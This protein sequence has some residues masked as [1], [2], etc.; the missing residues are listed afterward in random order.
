MNTV[1]IYAVALNVSEGIIQIDKDKGVSGARNIVHIIK[2]ISDSIDID[3][4]NK[5]II[6]LPEFAL[7]YR[8]YRTPEEFELLLSFIGKAISKPNIICFAGTSTVFDEEKEGFANILP[9]FVGENLVYSYSKVHTTE[10]ESL[11]LYENLGNRVCSLTDQFNDEPFISI[12]GINFVFEICNDYKRGYTYSKHIDIEPDLH[13]IPSCGAPILDVKDYSKNKLDYAK[14][15][16]IFVKKKGFVINVESSFPIK[17]D[18]QYN[19]DCIKN[20]SCVIINSESEQKDCDDILYYNTLN[21]DKIPVVKF[22]LG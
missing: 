12:D 5:S 3:N 6:V 1:E 4:P 18:D 11:G 10:T 13:I 15:R 16:N 7:G 21:D 14:D 17:S 19:I 8:F 22:T 20:R 2:E 9:I